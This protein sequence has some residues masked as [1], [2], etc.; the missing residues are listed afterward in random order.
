[1]LQWK[2]HYPTRK[3]NF[4]S[5]AHKRLSSN[6]SIHFQEK[7]HNVRFNKQ[8]LR[9]TTQMNLRTSKEEM[10]DCR[11][12]L[13]ALDQTE[14]Q[15]FFHRKYELGLQ[16]NP[17]VNV[18]NGDLLQIYQNFQV[19]TNR[20]ILRSNNPMFHLYGDCD[21]SETEMNS[22]EYGKLV[23][24]LIRPDCL[25][26]IEGGS[27]F[28]LYHLRSMVLD[29]RR[30]DVKLLY[31]YFDTSIVGAR[32]RQR[33]EIMLLEGMFDEFLSHQTL[34]RSKSTEN[35]EARPGIPNPQPSIA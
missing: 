22:H 7:V 29:P 8:S 3:S 26:V 35:P 21:L 15:T 11:K 4:Y 32:L 12:L 30:F 19:F 27:S 14:V 17:H 28:Y 10:L 24:G 6:Q 9:G 18:I 16:F 33:V 5:F 1:M 25:N 23:E 13:R 2:A 34:L 20:E 31:T